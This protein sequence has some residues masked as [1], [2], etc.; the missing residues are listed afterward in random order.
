MTQLSEWSD[1]KYNKN[2]VVINDKLFEHARLTRA[3]TTRTDNLIM[4]ILRL[5][6]LFWNIYAL[7]K[8]EKFILMIFT[9]I[10]NLLHI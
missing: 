2:A 6:R 7:K 3:N 9:F 8:S 1:E 10:D 4:F 5:K